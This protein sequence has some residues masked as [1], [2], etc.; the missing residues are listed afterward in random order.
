MRT[1]DINDIPAAAR[2]EIAYRLD[3]IQRIENVRIILA[4]ESGSRAWGFASP[5]SDYDA[6]FIYVRPLDR[7]L[8][9]NEG[10]DVIETP[11]EDDMDVSGWDI[12]KALRLAVSHNP[13]LI[14]WLTS[15]IIYR[16]TPEARTLRDFVLTNRSRRALVRHYFGLIQSGWRRHFASEAE[17]RVPLK[18][19]FYVIRPAAALAWLAQRPDETPP[20]TLPRLLAGLN[21]PAPLQAQIAELVALKSVTN[22]LGDGP[23]RADIDDFARAQMLWGE[24]T[25][26][27][28][29]KDGAANT[30]AIDALFRRLIGAPG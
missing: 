2:A 25:L 12:R 16:E 17:T 23:R 6:R 5:D 24:R 22:E 11:I 9:L 14:E 27:E 20:M 7:Y 29:P 30:A 28:L 26:A 3:E 8:T 10:R 19:Y 1:P 13:V 18:R 21:L 15:T 4:V